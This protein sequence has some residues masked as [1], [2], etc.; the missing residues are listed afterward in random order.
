VPLPWAIYPPKVKYSEQLPE[1]V[2]KLIPIP[3]SDYTLFTQSWT[4]PHGGI[5]GYLTRFLASGDATFQHIAT[6]T[7]L[8]LL[9]SEDKKLVG[10]IRDGE[11]ILNMIKDIAEQNVEGEEATEG[12][13]E[14]V[15]EGE[16]EVV[17]LARKCLELVEGG[18]K[19][20]LV[21][22]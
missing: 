1:K 10:L 5:S 11:K 8:Q 9:E 4:S 21:E 20:T 14:G 16:G 19:I 2:A 12:G 6:W 22:G 18:G 7:L 15:E 17:G 3:V 13:E